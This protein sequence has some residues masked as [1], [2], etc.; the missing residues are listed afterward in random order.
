[1]TRGMANVGSDS[2]EV[3]EGISS[4]TGELVKNVSTALSRDVSGA[5]VAV[6]GEVGSEIRGNGMSG[7]VDEVVGCC[8]GTSTEVKRASVAGPSVV[9]AAKDQLNLC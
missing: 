4:V 1:M 9:V 3:V 8:S 2:V 6:I 5:T 7:D